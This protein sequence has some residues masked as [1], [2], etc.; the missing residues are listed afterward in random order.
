VERT[1]AAVDQYFLDNQSRFTR[2]TSKRCRCA[3]RS[4]F[5]AVQKEYDEVGADDIQRW[6]QELADR[7]V[8]EHTI[9][10]HLSALR[11]FYG[12][13]LA[14][15]LV[16][17]N[18]VLAK[19]STQS[20]G[21][22][23]RL[24]EKTA[25]AINQYCSDNQSRLSKS[26]IGSAK[27]VVKVFFLFCRKEYDEVTAADVACWAE[28]L[29]NK[30]TKPNTIGTGLSWLRSFYNYCLESGLAEAN[31]LSNEP[32]K[33]CP[34]KTAASIDQ[35]LSDNQTGFSKN[36]A[37]SYRRTLKSLFASC[38]KE[39][40]QVNTADV[41]CWAE[42]QKN[43]GAKQ[44]T[45]INDLPRL[46]SFYN[47]C[48][49]RGLVGETPVSV[50]ESPRVIDIWSEFPEKTAATLKQYFSDQQFA[51]GSIDR[52]RYAVKNFF[53]F[54]QIEYDEVR[55][56]DVQLWEQEC[57]DR[58]FT[59][60][61][62]ASYL[63][64]LRK[65]YDYCLD[66]GLVRENPVFLK[67]PPVQ[68]GMKKTAAAVK[69]YLSEDS[70]LA[71]RTI[72]DRRCFLACFFNVCQ[73]EFNR[74]KPADIQHWIGEQKNK[75]NKTATIAGGLSILRTFY[76]YCLD[77]GLVPKIPVF[78]GMHPQRRQAVSVQV[79]LPEKTAAVI[80][81][82]LADHQFTRLA[83]SQKRCL[84]KHFF[85]FCRK[86]YDE[87][88]PDDIQC[89]VDERKGRGLADATIE[90]DK[91]HLRAFYYYCLKQDMVIEN[92]VLAGKPPSLARPAFDGLGKTDAAVGQ[93]FSDNY[94]YA[95]GTIETEYCVIKS[96]FAF[97]QKEYDEVKP[98][99]IRSWIGERR[100]KKIKTS[101]IKKD[102]AVL[103]SFYDY[104][105]EEDLLQENPASKVEPPRLGE[106]PPLS[107][108]RSELALLREETR[109]CLRERAIV[110]VLYDTGARGGELCSAKK[111][112]VDMDGRLITIWKGK[113]MKARIIPFTAE[114]AERLKFYL[115][116]RQDDSPYLFVNKLGKPLGMDALDRYF[117]DISR[118]LG[119]RVW[120]HRL[121]HTFATY[122]VE[123]G[124]EM[125][126]IQTLMGHKRISTTQIYARL[127]PRAR[128][129]LYDRFS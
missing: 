123:K 113:G 92:P 31:P 129:N 68:I 36:T 63:S 79:E 106:R 55:E 100:G 64:A 116:S 25:A 62:I 71:R 34:D 35:Y 114:C 44:N 109:T 119:F 16:G 126:K 80:K 9:A 81:G 28:E 11:V 54:C 45:I 56:D 26:T 66:K 77:H 27:R 5:A 88:K 120:P 75:G 72:R 53:A 89:W 23:S 49:D 125:E 41:A 118:R 83:I 67:R 84:L 8:R 29:K 19:I 40:D 101:S 52:V 13:Y 73:K 33:R 98:G 108:D 70:G 90:L 93:Y 39:Y 51:K 96:F 18:P 103:K 24:P 47:Y 117:R 60:F 50:K 87:V 128:K 102:L 112:D 127:S 78:D 38:Q 107:L 12:Y 37:E 1:A 104:C 48:L 21:I 94:R 20:T 57:R 121:R 124:M 99:D 65:L 95:S 17:D 2:S 105:L 69:Q 122:L 97:C 61:T 91:D 32:S 115:A 30:G 74:I 76:Y 85:A 22:W 4:L 110:E 82:Y 59:E 86:E 111:E 46:R 15:G 10:Q 43:K 6:E 42:E 3:I 14:R 58:R 7:G